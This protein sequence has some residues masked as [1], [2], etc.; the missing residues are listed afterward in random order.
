MKYNIAD[1]GKL[2]DCNRNYMWY[3]RYNFFKFIFRNAQP[4]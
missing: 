4:S 2:A 3:L 1:D